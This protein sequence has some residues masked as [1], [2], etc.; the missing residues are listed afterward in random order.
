MRRII[1]IFLVLALSGAL[2]WASEGGPDAFGYRWIDSEEPGGPSFE[3]IEISTSGSPMRLSDDSFGTVSLPESFNF[4]GIDYNTL[5]ICSNGWVSFRDGSSSIT[6]GPFPGSYTPNAVLGIFNMDLDPADSPGGEIYYEFIG[7]QMIVEYYQIREYPGG[8]S[9]PP[10]TFEIIINFRAKSI[11]FQYLTVSE[12]VSSYRICYIGIEDHNGTV[13]LQYGTHEY[14]SSDL[15]DSLAIIFRSAIVVS[16]FYFD[17]LNITGE[18]FLEDIEDI[19]EWEWGEPEGFMGPP[20]AH[21][22]PNCFGTVLDGQYSAS[23]AYTL[24]SPR[25]DLSSANAP[26]LEFWHWYQT[27]EGQ[28][29]GNIKVTINDGGTWNIIEPDGGYPVSALGT[30][31]ELSGEAAFSGSSSGWELV[32]LDLESFIGEELRFKFDFASD[33]DDNLAGWYIDDFA[34]NEKFGALNGT[35]SLLFSGTN[36]G[37]TI[38]IPELGLSYITGDDGVYHID[39][40]LVGEYIVTASKEHYVTVVDSGI[41][42]NEGETAIHDFELRPNFGYLTG[43]VDLLYEDNDAGAIVEIVELGLM[44]TT[45]ETGYYFIDTVEIGTYSVNISKPYFISTSDSGIVITELDTTIANFALSPELYNS[46]F[47]V[48]NG[49]LLATPDSGGWEW[50]IPDPSYLPGPQYACTGT[51]CWGTN[52]AGEYGDNSN[53]KLDFHLYLGL[54]EFPAMTVM[55][56]YRFN[57]ETSSQLFEGGNVKISVDAGANWAILEP[58]EGYINPVSPHNVFLG[59]QPAFGGMEHGNFWH[60]LNFDLRPYAYEHAIIRFE[61]GTDTYA[62]AAGWYID[63]I[64]VFEMT[65]ISEDMLKLP[66][67]LDLRSYPNPFNSTMT[68]DFTVIE[69][70]D[71]KI[72]IYNIQGRKVGTILDKELLRGNYTIKWEAGSDIPSGVYL[73]LLSNQNRQIVKR[74]IL[75]R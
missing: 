13:G 17:D 21:S 11:K 35:A 19:G 18:S 54:V 36:R 7:D 4:Y 12:I 28:D 22:A 52:L 2:L 67:V 39:T 73:V 57:G 65:G 60:I 62:G 43:Y 33:A 56:W 10:S 66:R 15:H 70:G 1:V 3:W 40:V 49:G 47:E 59:N 74:A 48:D 9:Y 72:D 29:G 45:D 58:Q 38:E 42:I 14:G 34:L 16:P 55:H 46:S 8:T 26:Y 50:G 64:Q 41:F 68:L 20:S 44:D 25:I 63:D 37:V 27:E 32:H 61:I 23:A 24:I 71:A 69:N 31:S 6:V 30:G 51:K 53:W 5:Y 75:L